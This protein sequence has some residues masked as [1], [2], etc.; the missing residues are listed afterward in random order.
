MFNKLYLLLINFI[1]KDLTEFLSKS[2]LTSKLHKK[3]E[4]TFTKT[5][6]IIK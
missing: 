6:E 4:K 3:F 1:Y 2:V 5:H